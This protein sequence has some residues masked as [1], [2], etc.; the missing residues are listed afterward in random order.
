MRKINPSIV[1]LNYSTNIYFP[2]R[3][4]GDVF[5]NGRV[6]FAGTEGTDLTYAGSPDLYA[7]H[8]INLAYARHWGRPCWAQYPTPSEE[9]RVFGSIFFAPVTGNGP[10]GWLRIHHGQTVAKYCGWEHLEESAAY[11]DPVADVGVLL[12]SANRYGSRERTMAHSAEAYGW[13]QAFGLRGV[14]FNPVPGKYAAREHVKPYRALIVPDCLMLPKHTVGLVQRYVRE[15]G[16]AV[17]TGVPGRYDALYFPLGDQ[18][19]LRGMGLRGIAAAQ[20]VYFHR[21]KQRFLNH[22]DRTITLTPGFLPGMPRRIR[23]PNCYRFDVTFLPAT[24]HTVLA[25]FSDGAPAVCSIPSGEGRY[26]YLGFLPGQ[27][28]AQRRMSKRTIVRACHPPQVLDLMRAV[29]GEATGNRDRIAVE[30]DGIISSAWQKGKRLWVRMVNVSGVR[31]L[32]I[33]KPVGAVKPTYP[34]L[35]R[36]RIHVRVPVKAKARLFTPDRD[37][38]VSLDLKNTD[39]GRVLDISADTFKTF[40]FVRLETAR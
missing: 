1:I 27:L 22:A 9:G 33:G 25:R 17:V 11:A 13:L 4:T 18:S 35:G 40:A 3:S 32:P 28:S 26:V 31:K 5:E 30:A 10:W 8:R 2:T 16:T 37:K 24:T 21:K 36:I 15:G 7:Q 14:Q 12:S 23:L 6:C 38:P 39:A 29:A 19:L 20:D 34:K